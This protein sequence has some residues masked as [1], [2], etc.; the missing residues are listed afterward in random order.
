MP[1]GRVVGLSD[2]GLSVYDV[3]ATKAERVEVPLEENAFCIGLRRRAGEVVVSTGDAGGIQILDSTTFEAK[4]KISANVGDFQDSY[5]NDLVVTRDERLA[6]GVDIAHQRVLVFDLAQRLLVGSTPA[7]REPYALELSPDG[8]RLFV[9]NIGLF[10]Y[11][12]IPAGQD[13]GKRLTRPPFGFPSPEA[14]KGVPMEGRFVPGLGSAY[15]A[16]AQSVFVYDLANPIEPALSRRVK[17]GILIHAPA[18]GGKSVGGSAPNDLLLHNGRLYVSCANNDIVQVFDATTMK[19]VGR[20]KLTA[21]P[22]LAKH[23]GVIPSGMAVDPSGRRLFVAESGINSVAAIELKTLKVIG[24]IPTGWFPTALSFSGDGKTLFIATQKGI[25][26]GPTGAY[27]VRSVQDERYGF[28]AMPG[29]IDALP[30]PTDTQLRSWNAEVIANNGLAAVTRPSGPAVFPRVFGV[31]SPK[32]RHVVFITKENHT[33]DGIF[34]ELKSRGARAEPRYAEWGRQGWLREKG[35]DE[36][37][38]VMPNH[39]SLAEQFAISDNFYMEPQAS[40]DGHRWLVGV[41]PSLW[42]TRVFYS[43][44]DYRPVTN[45][46]GRFVSFGSYGSQIPEDYLENGSIWE[47][48]H[49]GGLSFRNYGEGYEMPRGYQERTNNRTG[50]EPV[51]NHPMPKVLYDNTDFGFPAYNT[52]VPDVARADWFQEDI[53][54]NFR[55]KGRALPRFLNIALCNDH[56]DSPRPGQG[57]PYTA[58]YMADNDLALGRVVEYLSRQPEWKEMVIFVTQDDSGGDSDSVDRHRSYVLAIGPYCKRGYISRDHTSIMSIIK[59]IY[60]LLGLPANNLFDAVATDLH[61][62]FTDKP[63]FAPYR[64]RPSD[65]RVFVE[66]DTLDPLDPKFEKRRQVSNPVRMDD[67]DFLEWLRN[68]GVGEFKKKAERR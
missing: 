21:T 9:A 4:A 54:R 33:F 53:E 18:D 67:P 35:R 43:G 24:R 29:M 27:H 41:Y 59:S 39:L 64:H 11:R 32:I 61:D 48:I 66:S 31:A 51:M 7:G 6:Y 60:L 62:L 65:P 37:V 44:W 3:S 36:R 52:W 15:V 19:Q 14:E 16:D 58:S 56:G 26:R 2:G 34:G 42:T 49:R 57:Y 5:V 30:T 47:H 8:K 46:P 25:G 38:S 28:P 40:G 23:R 68:G 22:Q 45:A 12:L 20:V 63:N 13:G 55:R 50:V 1:D 10:D 17:A